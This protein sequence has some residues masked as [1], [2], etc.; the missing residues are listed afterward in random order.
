MIEKLEKAEL[1]IGLC[2]DAQLG[3]LLDP[4]LPNL[5]GF[6][7]HAD[8]VVRAKVM[9]I[10]S[11]L[12]MRIR[13]NL[14]MKLPL[15]ALSKQFRA[16]STDPFVSNFCVVYLEMGLA[17][18]SASERAALVPAL[19]AGVARRSAAQQETL[20]GL[21]LGALPYLALPERA[22]QI[23]E[24]LPFLAEG[25]DR[26]LILEWALDL[27]QYLPPMA[28]SSAPPG[29]SPAAAKRV[30]GKLAPAEVSSSR[31]VV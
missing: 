28:E 16:A 27:L 5:L 3:A 24:T 20:L 25:A 9:A 8:G 19:L 31:V 18:A 6:L 29:L 2:E 30:C 13:G 17:R 12:N 10:L 21:L 22:A 7:A 26:L 11:H 23:G 4:A 14:S 15:A 1:R